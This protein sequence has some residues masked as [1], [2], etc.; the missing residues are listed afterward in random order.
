MSYVI[1]INNIR[2]R[3]GW[4]LACLAF[5]RPSPAPTECTPVISVAVFAIYI[6]QLS[7]LLCLGYD[8]DLRAQCSLFV[9]EIRFWR[10]KAVVNHLKK[11]DSVRIILGNL[12][13]PR[14]ILQMQA[15]LRHWPA[16]I[17]HNLGIILV[18]I[19][20]CLIPSE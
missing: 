6:G 2:V 12:E 1:V 4:R 15:L 18:L 3:A 14:G 20:I 17:A 19:L 8:S 16:T 9:Y 11:L 13:L 10:P 5:I 7:R